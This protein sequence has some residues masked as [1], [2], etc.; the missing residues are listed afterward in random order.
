MLL[1]GCFLKLLGAA[2]FVYTTEGGSFWVLV[3]GSSIGVIS[4][5]GNEVRRTVG[6]EN[7]GEENN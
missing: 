3:I 6:S 2:V 1:L 4:P 5:S 7:Q